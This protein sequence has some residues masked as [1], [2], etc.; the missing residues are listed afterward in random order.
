MHQPDPLVWNLLTL[1]AVILFA[2]FAAERIRLP[3]I[4]GLL[5]GGFFVGPSGLGILRGTDEVNALGEIG[6]F[7]LMFLAGLEL[8]LLVFARIRKAAI[9]FGLLTFALPLAAGATVARLL[10]F[11]WPASILIGSLWASHTLVMY[12]IIQRY[13]L[14]ADPSVATTVGATVITDTLALLVLAVI[15][16]SATGEATLT[17][18]L[19]LL[20]G[21]GVTVAWCFVGLRFVT[22]WFFAGLGQDRTLRFIF[23]VAAFLSAALVAELGGIE[24]IVGAFFAGLALN[25]LV[26]NGGPLMDRVEFFGS[27]LFIPAFLVSVGL[28]IDPAVLIDPR[29]WVLAGAFTLALVVGKATAAIAIGRMSHFTG[30]Q[31]ALVL[32]LSLSQAA[33][34]LAATAV[35]AAVGLF[36]EAV[37]NAVVLVIVASLLVSSLLA[38]RAASRIAPPVRDVRPIGSAI[39]A[40]IEDAETAARLAPL[41][42]RIAR[43]D[44]GTLMPVHVVADEGIEADVDAGRA[45]SRTID[46]Q[47]RRSGVE[48]D[49]SLRIAA[50]VRQGL[51]NEIRTH[52]GSL[53]VV[54]RHGAIRPQDFLF[55]GMSEEIAGASPV[56]VVVAEMDEAPVARVLVPLREADLH[57]AHHA[58][59]R[60]ALELASRLEASGLDLVIGLPDPD[61]VDPNVSLPADAARIPLSG[62][63]T[64]WIVANAKPGDLVLI[65]AGAT[66]P[67]FGLDAARIASLPGVSAAVVAG[68]LRGGTLSGPGNVSGAIVGRTSA[69]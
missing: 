64:R 36:D 32:S 16:G 35:G 19:L 43:R 26:P 45:V 49:P 46:D 69:A 62:G 37:V 20:V 58:E 9:S 27:S 60:L 22:T 23:I 14:M 38:E 50:S 2:P 65:P 54:A 66:G 8:D 5:L 40:A 56:P 44:G 34:T 61:R 33:A 41:F 24:G 48:A 39:V 30:D 42:A 1:L 21:L 47:V 59:T 11:D 18:Q 55:G 28:L 57:G 4:I 29:T 31:V 6:L 51:R 67:V 53:L 63:R 10:G 12:P 52:D 13:G 15:A 3:G 68:P 17:S 7:Y 25:R